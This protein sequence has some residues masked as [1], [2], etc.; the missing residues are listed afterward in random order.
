MRIIKP[1]TVRLWMANHPMT[2]SWLARWM[3]LTADAQWTNLSQVRA[4]F[5]HADGVRVVSGKTVIVFNVGKTGYRLITA[6]H[7][8]TGVVYAMRLMTHADY[9]KRKWI[10]AL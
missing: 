5:P 7:Y 4:S 2:A 9:D 3:Q 8:R 1:P 6:I 10:D